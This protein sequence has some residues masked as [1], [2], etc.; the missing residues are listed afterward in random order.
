M[1]RF[2]PPPPHLDL[3]GSCQSWKGLFFSGPSTR[4]PAKVYFQTLPIRGRFS[5]T[6]LPSVILS[7]MTRFLLWWHTW[8]LAVWTRRLER[9]NERIPELRRRNPY[10][11]HIKVA[12]QARYAAMAAQAVHKLG[13]DG[14]R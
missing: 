3:S 10:S 4:W 12:E 14:E 6:C 8:R 9:L 13:V 5:P 2:P 11:H 1:V 7:R